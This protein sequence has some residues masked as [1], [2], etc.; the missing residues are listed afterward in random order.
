M[1]TYTYVYVHVHL[2]LICQNS[3]AAMIS[4]IR[5]E[6]DSD[7]GSSPL[8]SKKERVTSAISQY[9]PQEI[10]NSTDRAVS[11]TTDVQYDSEFYKALKCPICL[12]F[13]EP[14]VFICQNG[15]SVCSK[16]FK[17]QK[18]TRCWS[19]RTSLNGARNLALE[20]VILD[21]T[22]P[23]HYRNHG[24]Q[25]QGS[26]AI[27]SGHEATCFF[28]P[29]PCF[30]REKCKWRGS[31]STML[32][33]FNSCDNHR[34]YM[35]KDM[36]KL[37]IMATRDSI[38][39]GATFTFF[40]PDLM[41]WFKLVISR[42]NCLHY[43]VVLWIPAAEEIGTSD[44]EGKYTQMELLSRVWQYLDHAKGYSLVHELQDDDRS[45]M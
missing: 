23:C 33:H 32:H 5:K 21:T 31:P 12:F 6:W 7:V 36:T 19:C 14:T 42:R 3:T 11:T 1:C 40:S 22:F 37:P 13:Y 45:I 44:K 29:I 17:N 16:C 15:H 2:Y 43:L 35:L 18:R 27:R 30:S 26:G 25:Y 8:V 34:Y 10:S 41:R 38:L 9:S 24:C 20:K 39:L 4:S 28:R